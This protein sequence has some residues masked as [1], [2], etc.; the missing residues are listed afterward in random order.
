MGMDS[1]MTQHCISVRPGMLGKLKNCLGKKQRNRKR[2]YY[3][4]L[5][6]IN[7][8]NVS[9]EKLDGHKIISYWCDDFC[10]FLKDI[11]KYIEGQIV[12]AFESDAE[13]PAYVCFK[14]GKVKIHLPVWHELTPDDLIR[15][16]RE[17][18]KESKKQYKSETRARVPRKTGNGSAGS[19]KNRCSRCG[20]F[21]PKGT[22]TC[23]SFDY[24]TKGVRP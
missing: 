2:H 1:R 21:I 24:L 22:V 12:F 23:C 5:V 15:A 3:Y 14:D 7:G 9:L 16:R 6:E 8:K 20:R 10:G 4:S 17:R 11:A 19:H 13:G 18:T